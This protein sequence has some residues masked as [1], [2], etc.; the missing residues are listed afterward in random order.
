MES[1]ESLEKRLP[2]LRLPEDAD[3]ESARQSLEEK[4][5]RV[6][7]AVPLR[8]LGDPEYL[9]GDALN[10]KTYLLAS[11]LPAGKRHFVYPTPDKRILASVCLT[12]EGPSISLVGAP[13][14]GP[15]WEHD[16]VEGTPDQPSRRIRTS[17]VG[18][19]FV[20]K[21]AALSKG[22]GFESETTLRCRAADAEN[23]LLLETHRRELT[24]ERKTTRQT[25]VIS[26]GNDG[27]I[28][29]HGPLEQPFEVASLSRRSP[30]Q[31]G[32]YYTTLYPFEDFCCE[33]HVTVEALEGL[34]VPAGTF[35]TFRLRLWSPLPER[36]VWFAPSLNATVKEE[37]HIEGYVSCEVLHEYHLAGDATETKAKLP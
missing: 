33:E 34:A 35:E 24:P 13:P 30:M 2:W 19:R 37:V 12:S 9:R 23:R 14:P 28:Y 1:K 20:Y 31:V 6:P 27:E 16:F 17:R 29:E 32:Q 8:A 10:L 26:Q 5:C 15:F 3:R 25:A 4:L 7:P 11:G 36:V 18:D 22:R 21:S